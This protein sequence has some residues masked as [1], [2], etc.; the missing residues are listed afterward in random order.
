ML[1]KD[2][3]LWRTIVQSEKA[4][5][6]AF[7]HEFRL[8]AFN[9]AHSDEFFRIYAHRVQIGEVFPDLFAPDQAAVIRGFMARALAGETFEVSEEFGDPAI[10]K[11]YWS[12]SYNPL[13]NAGGEIIG[14]FHL[15]Q[16]ITVRLR[17]EAALNDMRDF[18]RLALSA[19]G[20]VG[21]WTFDATIDE[22]TCDA[23]VATLYGIDPAEG[24]RGI[25]RERFLANVHQ[26][27]MAALTATMQGGLVRAGDLELEYRIR[28]PDGATR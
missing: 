28:H 18:A 13:R 25:G 1:A 14:A 2:P 26:D 27:D 15:A 8:I 9:Q 7:D 10:A 12:I 16:D 4:P 5:V 17:T 11:P 21:A 6:C 20:G 3:E 22:F 23:A 19:V 24:A